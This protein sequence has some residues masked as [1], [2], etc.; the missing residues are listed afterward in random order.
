MQ[1]LQ[2]NKA[3]NIARAE[4]ARR[5]PKLGNLT[6]EQETNIETLLI[7]TA[8]QVLEMIAAIELKLNRGAYSHLRPEKDFL[9]RRNR[10][11]R[12]C[13]Y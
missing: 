4:M 1:S 12:T 3:E 10:D 13:W 11:A 9:H 5:R 6:P 7:S 2:Q 8:N